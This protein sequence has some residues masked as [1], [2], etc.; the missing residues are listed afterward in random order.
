MK[1]LH[2]VDLHLGRQ[3]NSIP[4]ENDHEVIL[5]QILQV[6]QSLVSQRRTVGLI[7]HVTIVKENI[8]N[9]LYVRKGLVGSHIETR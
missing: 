1:I 2:T 8:P 5:D 9:G 6:L 7:S 4:L 3:F